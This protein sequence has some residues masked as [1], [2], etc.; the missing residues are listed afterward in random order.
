MVHIGKK[1]FFNIKQD[2]FISVLAHRR[3]ALSVIYAGKSKKKKVIL[4]SILPHASCYSV[5]Y[6]SHLWV[7]TKTFLHKVS[8]YTK[9]NNNKTQM[10]RKTLFQ[11]DP[12]GLCHTDTDR[13]FHMGALDIISWLVSLSLFHRCMAFKCCRPSIDFSFRMQR[14]WTRILH[15]VQKNP[16]PDNRK[17]A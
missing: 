2:S 10:N 13:C 5:R 8:M 14:S 3:R 6:V 17:I 4:L 16:D 15:Q 12:S 1:C 11:L 7:C 9:N